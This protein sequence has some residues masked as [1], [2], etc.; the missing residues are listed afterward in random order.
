VLIVSSTKRGL[1]LP[2]ASGVIAS[3]SFNAIWN[4]SFDPSTK[5]PPS[6]W[7]SSWDGFGEFVHVDRINLANLF[8][9]VTCKNLLYAMGSSPLTNLVTAQTTFHFLH[10]TPLVLAMTNGVVK[11]AHVV[12]RDVVIDFTVTT[13]AGPLLLYHFTGTTGAIATNSGFTGSSANGIYTN[14]VVLG[15]AGPRPPIYTNYSAGNTAITLDGSDDYVRGTNGLLNNVSGFTLAG[16]IKPSTETL[17]DLDLF[18]QLG[19]AQFGFTTP[20][21]KL[22]LWCDAG[23]KK[24]HYFY[25]YGSGEWHHIAGVA[26]GATM[27]IFVDAVL[28]ASRIYATTAYGSNASAFNVGGNVFGTGRYFP[29]MIDEVVVYDRALSDA[30]VAQLYANQTP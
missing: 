7:A 3:N 2:V 13:N 28:V 18:G 30:Q 5:S 14:G 19:L 1:A 16:W 24:L 6:G 20:S 4:W 15:G 8:H 10:G 25:P 11:R 23:S 27:K 17:K 22:E 9:A 26:D 29:G 21:G 12:T